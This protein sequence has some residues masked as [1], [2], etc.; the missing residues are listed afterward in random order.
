MATEAAENQDVN[1]DAASEFFNGKKPGTVI[2]GEE[3]NGT[4][5]EPQLVEVSVKGR[6]IKMSPEDAAAIEEFRREVRERDGRL[7]GENAQMRERLARLEGQ[8]DAVSRAPRTVAPAIQPPD[9][10]LVESDFAAY[11]QQLL[12]YQAAKMAEMQTELE[13]RYNADRQQVQTQT[14]EER[15][16]TAWANRF[17]ADYDHLGK[18]PRVKKIVAEV[19]EDHKA[20]IDSLG[21]VKE[22][23]ERLAELAD[24]ELLSLKSVSRDANLK[25]KPPRLEGGSTPVPGK[26]PAA[27]PERFSGAKWVAQKRAALR[28]KR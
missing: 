8:V 1:W 15:R 9:P 25:N 2:D 18:T 12:A 26:A 22:Q 6:K 7:G 4:T 13:N 21:S 24:S 11:H 5:Q 3:E 16:S 28:G 19:Y 10:K 14:E 17:Y 23:H 20:E 27:P